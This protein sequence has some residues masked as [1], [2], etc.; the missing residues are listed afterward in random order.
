MDLRS[1]W[2]ARADAWVRRAR[3]PAL[4]GDFWLFHLR[5]FVDL[6]SAPGR[7]T[8]DV[9]CGEGRLTRALTAAGHRVVGAD[10]AS[11]LVKAA[12]THPR[13]PTRAAP[14]ASSPTPEGCPSLTDRQ[15]WT[16]ARSLVLNPGVFSTPIT[17]GRR[18][19]VL[20]RLPSVR[21][22]ALSG[23][24]HW[25]IAH[26]V[27]RR[28]D[29]HP[30]GTTWFPWSCRQANSTLRFKAAGVVRE[31][32][33]SEHLWVNRGRCLRRLDWRWRLTSRRWPT[34]AAKHHDN[35]QCRSPFLL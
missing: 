30:R 9:G 14:Q 33:E 12:L 3:S 8:V 21:A 7:L 29:P 10:T 17:D 4:D 11:A 25:H 16:K 5:S 28:S 1:A 20:F 13:G 34:C 19:T 35:K 32:Q 2:R 24:G 26:Q 22:Q 6:R 27:P 15:V 18:R 23:L 31:E